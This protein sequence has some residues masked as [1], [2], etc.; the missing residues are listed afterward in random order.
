MSPITKVS[1]PQLSRRLGVLCGTFEVKEGS[2][3]VNY[4]FDRRKKHI[5]KRSTLLRH[6]LDYDGVWIGFFS[7]LNCFLEPCPTPFSLAEKLRPQRFL[8]L[9]ERSRPV[10]HCR[11]FWCQ[12]VTQMASC[13]AIWGSLRLPKRASNFLSLSIAT[14]LHSHAK[15]RT[16][17]IEK[18]RKYDKIWW[19]GVG[20]WSAPMDDK[21]MYAMFLGLD[22]LI[23]SR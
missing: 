4:T 2:I 11:R 18:H 14:L 7:L 13:S 15:E 16:L 17:I 3:N 10:W 8:P 5:L 9:T 19:K 21:P 23:R 6:G 1:H 20:R 22:L 12:T